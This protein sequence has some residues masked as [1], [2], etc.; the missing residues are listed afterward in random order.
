MRAVRVVLETLLLMLLAGAMLV[1]V[2]FAARAI[3]SDEP[4]QYFVIGYY[5]ALHHDLVRW[6]WKRLRVVREDP[7]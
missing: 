6:V 2:I 3:F 1:G 7:A 4:S 5:A